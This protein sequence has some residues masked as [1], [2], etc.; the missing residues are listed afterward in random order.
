MPLVALDHRSE[1]AEGA[2]EQPPL[3]PDTRVGRAATG[4]LGNVHAPSPGSTPG[5]GVRAARCQTSRTGLWSG[6]LSPTMGGVRP[7]GRGDRGIGAVPAEP[8]GCVIPK[9]ISIVVP[10]FNEHRRLPATLDRLVAELPAFVED[11][12]VVVADDGSTD[13]TADVV[14]G[15]PSE[16]V[17][18]VGGAPNRGKG[19]ALRAGTEAADHPVVVFLDADLP[20]PVAQVVDLARAT[21]HADLVSGSRR[22]AGSSFDPPQPLARRLGGAGFLGAV[23]L[24]GYEITSDPQCG[25]KAF[26]AASVS[27]L[28]ASTSSDGFA[29]DVELIVTCRRSGLRVEDRPVAWRHVPGSTL[30]PVPDALRTLVD[31][32]RLRSHRARTPVTVP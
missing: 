15:H 8:R 31:L 29:F 12:E 27:P 24:L 25:V 3:D 20:V 30:H 13:A 22:V 28:V 21:D 4:R 23:R 10:A 17:R 14:R 16:R 19:A 6:A 5:A 26:R 2:P 18:L 7:Y 1:V 32:A 9:G 11:W